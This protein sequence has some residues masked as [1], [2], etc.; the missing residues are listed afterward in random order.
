MTYLI[1]DMNDILKLKTMIHE[2]SISIQTT[3]GLLM[4]LQVQSGLRSTIRTNIKCI[5]TYRTDDTLATDLV[6]I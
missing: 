4:Y 2:V 6:Y 5:K 1:F 3:D